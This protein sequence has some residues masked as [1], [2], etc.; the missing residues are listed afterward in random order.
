MGFK[1]LHKVKAFS[2]TTRVKDRIC[3]RPSGGHYDVRVLHSVVHIGDAAVESIIAPDNRHVILMITAVYVVKVNTIL[4][5]VGFKVAD[6][7]KQRRMPSGP[8]AWRCCYPVNDQGMV[9]K[10]FWKGRL[11]RT[12]KVGSQY[13]G[14]SNGQ[15][16]TLGSKPTCSGSPTSVYDSS[17]PFT[18]PKFTELPRSTA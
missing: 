6:N 10:L 17:R 18:L 13:I 15:N 11:K 14:T 8:A 1:V 3:R 4:V 7:P 12:R 16:D 5:A 9:R 2:V